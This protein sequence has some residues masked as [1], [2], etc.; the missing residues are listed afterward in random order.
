MFPGTFAPWN[1]SSRELSLPGAKVPGNFRSLELKFTVGTFA[2]RR[3]NTRERKVPEPLLRYKLVLGM[4]WLGY[5]LTGYEL[6][7]VRVDRHLSHHS[8]LIINF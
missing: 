6:E 2:P 3:E 1:E 7:W 4:R 8:L 5:E